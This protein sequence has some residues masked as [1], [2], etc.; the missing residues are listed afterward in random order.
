M[1]GI[2]LAH[3]LTIMVFVAAFGD[4]SGGHFNPSVTIGLTAAGEFP[5][6]RVVPYWMAQI[7]G[8]VAAGYSLLGVFGGPVNHLGATVVDTHRIT[9]AGA[10]VL[11][12]IGTFFLVNTVL[13]G[14]VRRAAGPL[15]PFAIGMTITMCILTFGALTGGSVNPARTIGPDVAAGIYDG[16]GVYIVAQLAGGIVAGVL[17]RVFWVPRPV[18]AGVPTVRVAGE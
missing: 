5:M 10:F 15:A 6:H 13:H 4:I 2:A 14:A 16:I 12:A 9:Y 18:L 17:Y 8:A 1:T 11:E 3:G 7:V